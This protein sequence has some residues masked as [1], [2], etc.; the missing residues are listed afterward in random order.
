MSISNMHDRRPMPLSQYCAL[1]HQGIEAD[2][3]KDELFSLTQNAFRRPAFDKVYE[4]E[5][6]R[7]AHDD[8]TGPG[9]LDT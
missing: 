2:I 5:L 8:G 1:V 7:V 6:I 4:Q 9:G 3:D